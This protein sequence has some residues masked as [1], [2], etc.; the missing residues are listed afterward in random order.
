MRFYPLTSEVSDTTALKA[1]YKAGRA[2]GKV[3]L[4]TERLFFKDG[5][6]V[7]Y[8]PYKEIRRA[9]RRV[10]LVQTKMCCGK[11]DLEVEN[12]VICGDAGE[13]AQIQLPGA[14]AGK[15]LLE[16]IARLAP[17]VQIGRPKEVE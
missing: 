13:L 1:E 10:L 8:I 4:G 5:L 3:Q 14:R 7:Y 12:F 16:E 15:V 9:F 11:G 17:H 2:I 6:K